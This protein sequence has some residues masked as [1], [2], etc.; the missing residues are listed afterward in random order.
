MTA[1]TSSWEA[2][3]RCLAAVD[4]HRE[5]KRQCR[6]VFADGCVRRVGAVCDGEPAEFDREHLPEPLTE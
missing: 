6:F 4:L 3:A 5:R 2:V 1:S